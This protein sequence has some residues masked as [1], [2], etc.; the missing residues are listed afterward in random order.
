MQKIDE[1]MEEVQQDIRHAKIEKYWKLYGKQAIIGCAVILGI[2]VIYT[3]YEN[4]QDQLS[5]LAS[6]KFIAGQNALAQGK[7]NDAMVIFE[8]LS[9]TAPKTYQVLS[10]FSKVGTLLKQDSKE[11]LLK[12]IET[13]KEIENSS[14]ADKGMKTLALLLRYNHEIGMFDKGSADFGN[15]RIKV[16]EIISQGGAWSYLARELKGIILYKVGAFSDSAEVFVS[17]V[18]DPQTPEAIK[19]RSQLMAQ[20]LASKITK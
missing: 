18:Q 11:S 14:S 1:F 7:F 13:L 20:V 15:I 3:L 16:D 12:A 19:T 9:K 5:L 10:L 17:L 6:E 2:S 8:D 4:R